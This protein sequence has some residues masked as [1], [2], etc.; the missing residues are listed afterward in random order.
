M[1][2]ASARMVRLRRMMVGVAVRMV[3]DVAAGCAGTALASDANKEAAAPS[4]QGCIDKPLGW[5]AVTGRNRFAWPTVTQATPGSRVTSACL[6]LTGLGGLGTLAPDPPERG[7]FSVNNGPFLSTEQSI[8]DGDRV[9]AQVIAGSEPDA[10]TSVGAR[11]NEHRLGEFSVRTINRG[12]EPRVFQV[13][14]SRRFRQL[15]DVAPLLSAGDQV[16]V[17]AGTYRP[18]VLTRS[19]TPDQPIVMR[20][21]D[22]RRPVIAGGRHSLRLVGAHHT[23]GDGF[24]ITG[25]TEA[26]V[27]VQ[28]DSVTLRNLYVH[29][30]PRHGILGA[31]LDS[32]S[33]VVDLSEI[34]RTGGHPVGENRKHPVYVATDR[35]AFPD[36]VLRVQRSYLHDNLGESIKSRSART[37][38]FFNWIEVGQDPQSLYT[39]SLYGFEAYETHGSLN[40]DV[41]GNVLVH[42]AGYG[43]RLG[44]DGTGASRGRVRFANNTFVLGPGF[45]QAPVMR[46]FQSLDSVFL[47][48]NAFVR[49]PP[50]M[51]P[52]RLFRDEIAAGSWVGGRIKLAG[53]KN[54]LPQRSSIAPMNPAEWREVIHDPPQLRSATP[55]E[56]DVRPREGS[57][58]LKIGSSLSRMP[59]DYDIG[60]AL[61]HLAW[62][63][64]HQAPTA[65]EPLLPQTRSGTDANIGAR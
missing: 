54:L 13:G 44:G 28:A 8:R 45:G 62:Q 5:P 46:L 25:G 65:G 48:N 63:V 17:D 30:C 3:I 40:S 55:G 59:A 53:E 24:E 32:G 11:L 60:G 57:P 41:V 6:R 9:L 16:L 10:L 43:V 33:L 15:S 64:W 37:E 42:Q 31:D 4:R 7:A 38:V 39:I 14:P 2:V 20:S 50:S 26:C 36:A 51:E 18:A 21:A 22:G 52:V 1:I 23:L 56:L 27:W 58:L 35:D 47:I 49:S 61:D 34:T 29:D 19:G 12:R